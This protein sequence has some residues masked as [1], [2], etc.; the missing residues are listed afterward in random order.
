M[1]GWATANRR[2]RIALDVGAEPV[3][4]ANPLLPH[5]R[6]EL[7]LP[8]IVGETV[9]GA[10][11]VQST[12]SG[13]FSEA[14]V[15]V[16]QTMADQIAIAL[17]NARLYERTARQARRERLVVDITSKI[18]ASNDMDTMVRTAVDE[19]R[20]ALGTS[21]AAVRLGGAAPAAGAASPPA[22]GQPDPAEDNSETGAS[23]GSHRAAAQPPD[24]NEGDSP[25]HGPN[26]T[27]GVRRNGTNGSGHGAGG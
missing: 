4:F 16:L 23:N 18:R 26:G 27:N 11:D 24:G 8:L 21:R 5:T 2:A 19:L 12:Q 1:V 14:D 9:L 25:A 15:A 6:S 10:L 17:Q 20:R 3:R 13:A 7:A 22:A